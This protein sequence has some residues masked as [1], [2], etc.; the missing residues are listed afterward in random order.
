MY[1]L[2]VAGILLLL[3]LGQREHLSF[4]TT[5]KDVRNTVDQAEQDRIFAMAPT[6]LQRRAQA[7]D[8]IHPKLL[9][10][11]II[12]DFQK[13]VYVTATAPITETVIN[14][15]VAAKRTYYTATPEALNAAFFLEA[16]TSGD[17]KRLLFSY[18]T[19]P[20]V[21]L[22]PDQA[23]PPPTPSGN[24][25]VY[26]VLDQMKSALLNYK[27]SGDARYKTSYDGLKTWMDQYVSSVNTQ[28]AQ[29][30]NSITQEV[31]QYK[32]ANTEIGRI[33]TDFR[34]VQREG[35]EVEN[36][37]LTLKKQM[38]YVPETDQTSFYVKVGIAVGLVLGAIVLSLV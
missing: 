22:P 33:Q 23:P 19:L 3:L 26:R 18:F 6:S 16:Y 28:L 2:L 8:P 36:A 4:T 21:A 20:S 17:A 7:A 14:S 35:P 1:P 15:F 25:S 11:T 29:E 5:I 31:N 24:V 30:A 37:Y 34:R 27:M 38:D 10:A 32:S 13:D 9:V 12:R